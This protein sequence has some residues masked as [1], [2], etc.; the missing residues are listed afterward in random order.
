M[1]IIS[2]VAWV[3]ILGLAL[4]ELLP[5]TVRPVDPHECLALC[6]QHGL[7]RVIEPTIDEV[8]V[9]AISFPSLDRKC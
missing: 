3:R 5:V 6:L 1:V 8:A 9:E 4:A 7:R 2:A